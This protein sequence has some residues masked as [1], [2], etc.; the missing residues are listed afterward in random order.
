MIALRDQ[1]LGRVQHTLRVLLAC[2]RAGNADTSFTTF[3]ARA[4]LDTTRM[5]A[6]N[7]RY[8]DRPSSSNDRL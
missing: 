8:Q 1:S 6:R 7:A 2:V 4:C 5:S 3:V